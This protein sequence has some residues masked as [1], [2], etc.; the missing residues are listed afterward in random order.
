[1]DI[2]ITIKARD[3]TFTGFKQNP[4]GRRGAEGVETIRAL[5]ADLGQGGFYNLACRRGLTLCLNRSRFDRDYH[6]RITCPSPVV[7][8]AFCMS[9]RT[10]TRVR[11]RNAS[12][13]MGAGDAFA[14]YFKEPRLEQQIRG[15]QSVG[16]LAVHFSPETLLRL[17]SPFNGRSFGAEET[18]RKAL[19]KGELSLSRPMTPQMNRLLREVLTC[20]HKGMFRKLFLESRT[21]ELTA[22]HLEQVFLRDFPKTS[23]RPLSPEDRDRIIHARD[24]LVGRLQ[25]PPA[26]PELAREAGMS[27]TRLTRGFKKL[28]GCTVFEY[29]RSER[30]NYGRTLL[31]EDRLSIT[32]A[33]LEAGFS[34][35]S[36]FAAA[37]QRAYGVSPSAYRSGKRGAAS[38]AQER[39]SPDFSHNIPH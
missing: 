31:E 1:M 6:A 13:E 8:F 22:C 21:L 16:V 23:A 9:G 19:K 32:E 30:L 35:S 36:H 25:F 14:Y 34:S 7:T 5:P 10:C 27:H 29:L 20:P 37:F 26:L 28:F 33:A 18:L 17:A 15:G 11:R 39:M 38:L 2:K 12:M 4:V 3:G 24:I